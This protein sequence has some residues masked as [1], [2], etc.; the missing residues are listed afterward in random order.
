[1]AQVAPSARALL[2]AG[3]RQDVSGTAGRE[4]GKDG[5]KALFQ[6]GQ[7]WDPFASL[8]FG[9]IFEHK[10]LNHQ[11][12]AGWALL[13]TQGCRSIAD[14]WIPRSTIRT[15]SPQQFLVTENT[16]LLSLPCLI[17][18]TEKLHICV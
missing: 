17:L 10:C 8:K 14:Q 9:H 2:L 1:M 3:W 16:G 15:P 6:T 7:C 5:R 12:L 4:A 18:T 11:T 13:G